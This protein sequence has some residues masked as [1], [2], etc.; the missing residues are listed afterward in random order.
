MS[1]PIGDWNP[2]LYFAYADERLRPALDLVARVPLEAPARVYD[3]GCGGGN[4]TRALAR[5]WPG[6]AVVGIDASPAMLARARADAPDLAFALGDLAVWAP[7]EPAD[8]I[9][10]NAAFHWLPDHGALLARLANGLA[11]GGVLAF[12]VP[13]NFAEPSHATIYET[14]AD[15]PWATRLAGRL[16]P[17]RPVEEP[18]W[19]HRELA[20]LGLAVDLW[21]TVY[22]HV[23][24]G[25]DPVLD[26]TR[27]T[28]LRP[29]LDLLDDGERPA[30]LA[31]HAARLRA[32]YPAE[33]DGRTLFPF[34]RLFVVARHPRG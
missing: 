12:Q 5:R 9:F 20:A 18:A 22:W 14:A 16:P 33:A 32:A 6:A 2:D 30:F 28:W 4:V 19:Y 15:G 23:L 13:R 24:A 1:D 27:A 29:V 7:P 17:R 3:L 8:L 34:R 11:P 10:S 26:W 25:P 31:A 21:E